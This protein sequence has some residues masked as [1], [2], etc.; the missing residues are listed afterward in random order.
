MKKKSGNGA[1]VKE[2]ISHWHLL[3][4][5]GVVIKEIARWD[6]EGSGTTDNPYIVEWIKNDPRNPMEWSGLRKWIYCTIM[7]IATLAISLSSSAYGGGI[8]QIQRDFHVSNE[9]ATLG[10]SMFVLGFALGPLL[11]AP[12]SEMYGRQVV[13]VSTFLAFVAF[14]AG[15]AGSQNIWTLIVHRFLASAFGSSSLT[16]AGGVIADMF[17]PKQRGLAMAVFTA[18]PTLGPVIGPIAGG[19]LGMKEGWRWIEGF[20]AILSGVLFI[21]SIVVVPETYAPTLLRKRA[22]TLSRTTGKVYLSKIA[23]NRGKRSLIGALRMGLR[24]PWVLLLREPIV[25]LLSLYMAVIYGTLFMFF[26]AYPIVYHVHRGWNQ[27]IANLPFISVA[28]DRLHSSIIAGVA[29]PVGLFW[30]AWTN[31]PS[32]PWAASAAAGIPFGFGILTV[33]LGITNYLVD[34]YTIYA[35][36]VLAA[37]NSLRCVFGAA[38][39]LFTSQM[40]SRLG[41]H[42]ASALPGFL[43]VACFP[44]IVTL[45]RYG[46]I[47]RK[48]CKYAA[49]A[50]AYWEEIH[51]QKLQRTQESSNTVLAGSYK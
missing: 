17:A 38:F 44:L 19:F 14:T 30:F 47:I 27:G 10:V 3:L 11:W 15:A 45:Y 12:F 39:P 16:N 4:D 8:E 29:L 41:I 48:R 37:N 50:Q 25:L 32:L 21:L 26:S 2:K 33:L 36:S 40:Y 34:A 46:A 6:Y 1:C 42:W 28:I 13:F 23:I 31:S 43:T 5:Q 7:G 9:V 18:A 35:A 20:L 49:E 24:R 51:E 22:R